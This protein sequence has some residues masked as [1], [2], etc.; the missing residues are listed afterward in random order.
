MVNSM[1][2][3]AQPERSLETDSEQIMSLGE[4]ISG[5]GKVFRPYD[6]RVIG[7][8]LV[9]CTHYMPK[10]CPYRWVAFSPALVWCPTIF[11]LSPLRSLGTLGA[12]IGRGWAKKLP[13]MRSDAGP[14]MGAEISI[15][16][17]PCD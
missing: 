3:K 6:W 16:E 9:V 11:L 7:V 1:Q 10:A 15:F 13:G 14:D 5:G 17:I 2:A 12:I 8:V 4:G